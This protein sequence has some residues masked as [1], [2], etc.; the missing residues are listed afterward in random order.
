MTDFM[1]IY[2]NLITIGR[3]E[4]PILEATGRRGEPTLGK[5]R[6]FVER[7][8]RHKDEAC[9]FFTN[10]WCLSTTIWRN[11]TSVT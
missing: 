6:S 7:M 3:L 1:N 2:D 10:L 5:A 8:A 11:V 4:H 9:L